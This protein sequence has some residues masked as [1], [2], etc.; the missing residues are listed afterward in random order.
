MYLHLSTGPLGHLG[1]PVRW[2]SGRADRATGTLGLKGRVSNPGGPVVQ[3]LV[4]TST[5]SVTGPDQ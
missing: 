5:G 1:G 3:A 4:A 2:P